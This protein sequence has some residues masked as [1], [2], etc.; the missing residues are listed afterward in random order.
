MSE[1]LGKLRLKIHTV[2]YCEAVWKAG[3]NGLS[4]K[5]VYAAIKQAIRVKAFDLGVQ[6]NLI[7]KPGSI[8]ENPKGLPQGSY[9]VLKNG[10]LL[11]LTSHKKASHVENR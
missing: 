10:T 2:D 9:L 3:L 11:L 1:K 5:K 7:N 8:L 6:I 4:G